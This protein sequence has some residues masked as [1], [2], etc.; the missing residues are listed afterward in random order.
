MTKKILCIALA[1]CILSALIVIFPMSSY[2]TGASFL[3]TTQLANHFGN[4]IAEIQSAHCW[5]EG[6]EVTAQIKFRHFSQPGILY[7]AIYA[8]DKLISLQGK[9]V[10][11]GEMKIIVKLTDTDEIQ[12]DYSAKIFYWDGDSLLNL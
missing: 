1:L 10:E 7:V 9:A 11:I 2:A 12:K 3:S 8:D 6:C 5:Y 4:S